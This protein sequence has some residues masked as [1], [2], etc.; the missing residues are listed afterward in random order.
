M[1]PVEEFL[2]IKEAGFLGNLAQGF[3]GDAGKS[4]G[5]TF[6]RTA[7]EGLIGAAVSTGI[8]AA[9]VGA[10]KGVRY[11]Q[12][13]FGKQRDYKNMMEAN[14]SLGDLPST[15]VQMVYNSLRTMAPTMAK[16]PLVAGSFVRRTMEL[17]GDTP[18]IDPMT[19]KLLSETQRNISQARKSRGPISEAFMPGMRIPSSQEKDPV[20]TGFEEERYQMPTAGRQDFKDVIKRKY[21]YE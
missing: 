7:R 16:D 11:I 3:V 6:G 5:H 19:A 4:V 20:Q 9:G 8:A 17:S 18:A 14:P 2:Q 13:R 10:T 15:Q 12:D 1:N 21:T